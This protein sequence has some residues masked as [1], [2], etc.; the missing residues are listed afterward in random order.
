MSDGRK[1]NANI[2]LINKIKQRGRIV[3]GLSAWLIPRMKMSSERKSAVPPLLIML[4]LLHFMA[5]RQRRKTV[6]RKRKP[7]VTPTVLHV[8]SL[9]GRISPF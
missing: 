7:S 3:T 8:R 6:V 4:V 9:M 1:A 5:L 2:L